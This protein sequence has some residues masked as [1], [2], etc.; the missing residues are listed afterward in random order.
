[1]RFLRRQKD[2]S[3]RE[4]WSWVSL[5]VWGFLFCFFPPFFCGE[6]VWFFPVS[7]GS[8]DF[9]EEIDGSGNALVTIS[10]ELS[11]LLPWIGD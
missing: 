11:C 8:D 6:W 4:G 10:N 7:V 3:G 5:F 1:M 2:V 9:S